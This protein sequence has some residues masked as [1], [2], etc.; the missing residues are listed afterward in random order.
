MN[1]E[2]DIK[3]PKVLKK[4]DKVLKKVKAGVLRPRKLTNGFGHVL[5]VDPWHRIVLSKNR[6]VLMTHSVY[7]NYI[8]NAH[9]F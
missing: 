9:K 1:I 7:N 3:D 5:E 4:V 2:T 6:A 8:K